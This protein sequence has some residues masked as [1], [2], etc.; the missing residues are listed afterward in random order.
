[1]D[2]ILFA[3]GVYGFTGSILLVIFSF[4]PELKEISNKKSW[5]F[6]NC[7]NKNEYNKSKKTYTFYSYLWSFRL[8]STGFLI[9]IFYSIFT[10]EYLNLPQNILFI[11]IDNCILV[12]VA[13]WGISHIDGYKLGFRNQYPIIFYF[14]LT[15]IIYISLIVSNFSFYKDTEIDVIDSILIL[16]ALISQIIFSILLFSRY[17]IMKTHDDRVKNGI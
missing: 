1:M 9:M 14:G 10:R 13:L 12:I 2:Q 7:K 6:F 15:I 5:K 17:H 4:L 3:T 8:I 11:L 16:S